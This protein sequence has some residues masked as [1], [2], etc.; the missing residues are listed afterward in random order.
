MVKDGEYVII[1]LR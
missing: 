1:S